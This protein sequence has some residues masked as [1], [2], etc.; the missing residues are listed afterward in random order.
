MFPTPHAV[1]NWIGVNA[2]KGSRQQRGVTLI[3]LMIAVAIVG[4]LATIAYPSY[5]NYQQTSRRSE[6]QSCLIQLAN[7]QERF[8]ASNGRYSDSYAE[9]RPGADTTCGESEVYDIAVQEATAGCPLSACFDLRAKPVGRQDGDGELRLIRDYR[10]PETGNRELRQRIK[11]S[12]TL[13]W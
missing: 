6:G 9:L 1:A 10:E 2:I 11:G 8:Y 5:Q 3:E 7:T 12:E 13:T 4:I